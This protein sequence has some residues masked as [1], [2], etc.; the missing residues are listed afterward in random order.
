MYYDILVRQ[1]MEDKGAFHKDLST[2]IPS[3]SSN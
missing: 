2:K 1:S 3:P